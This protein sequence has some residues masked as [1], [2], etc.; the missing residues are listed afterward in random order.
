[1]TTIRLDD[2]SYGQVGTGRYDVD[3]RDWNFQ[4]VPNEEQRL[5]EIQ[6]SLKTVAPASRIQGSTVSEISS[7]AARKTSPILQKYPELVPSASLLPQL[8]GFSESVTRHATAHEPLQASL[9]AVGRAVEGGG[10]EQNVNRGLEVITIAGG[11]T[12]ESVRVLPLQEALQGQNPPQASPDTCT[13]ELPC[14]RGT[15]AAVQQLC[16]SSVNKQPGSHL[17]VR[18]LHETA[19]LQS[20][21]QSS[22]PDQDLGRPGGLEPGPRISVS[23]ISS[24]GVSQTGGAHHSDVCFNPWNENQMAIIDTDERWS[25]WDIDGCCNKNF[26]S[27]GPTLL[28]KSTLSSGLEKKELS[29]GWARVSWASDAGILL[30]ANRTSICLSSVQDPRK[31]LMMQNLGVRFGSSWI[32]DLRFLVHDRTSLVVLTSHRVLLV[33]L[34]GTTSGAP[35]SVS[36]LHSEVVFSI[37]HNRDASDPTLRLCLSE[38]GAAVPASLQR[39]EFQ[40]NMRLTLCISTRTSSFLTGFILRAEGRS[41]GWRLD[42]DPFSLNMSIPLHI[43][44]D[45]G[46][47]AT[48]AGDLQMLDVLLVN[49][50]E[51]HPGKEQHLGGDSPTEP[52]YAGSICIFA[53]DSNLCLTRR[54]YAGIDQPK[55][56]VPRL[57]ESIQLERTVQMLRDPARLHDLATADAE[58]PLRSLVFKNISSNQAPMA[59]ARQKSDIYVSK[60]RQVSLAWLV[61]LIERRQR[62]ALREQAQPQPWSVIAERNRRDSNDGQVQTL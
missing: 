25:T 37:L 12:G 39:A 10:T 55:P 38:S 1:M 28:A 51:Y 26:G 30:T 16:F 59:A 15:R 11:P 27:A 52:S 3:V 6:G 34:Q 35:R 23:R 14:W 56:H 61:E 4:R 7:N 19:V 49:S 29:D 20:R 57:N 21:F 8:A 31:T 60:Q 58:S 44:D 41:G 54:L 5:V 62:R 40:S 32:I 36:Q 17:A 47:S 18:T 42:A 9:I 53:L 2:I 13:P 50:N 45:A 48:Q 33:R 46:V 24:I 43:S 22:H